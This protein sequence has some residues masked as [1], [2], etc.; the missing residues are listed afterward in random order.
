V[1]SLPEDTY[2]LSAR[3]EVLGSEYVD[4]AINDLDPTTLEFQ[5]FLTEICWGT[6]WTDDTLTR[7]ERSLL[8]LGMTAALGR[9]GEFRTHLVGAYRNGWTTEEIAAIIKQIS[10]YC[11]VPA[12][13]NATG[14]LREVLQ[15]G[16][17]ASADGADI[18][19]D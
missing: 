1:A 16:A 7:R 14:A 10:V 12:G 9:M 18:D 6:I 3:R 17:V 4:R 19:E 11:G 2:G 13:V 8:T 15:T 5:K